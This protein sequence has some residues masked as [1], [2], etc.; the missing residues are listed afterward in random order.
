LDPNIV[1]H[2]RLEV[3]NDV[4]SD[5]RDVESRRSAILRMVNG[6]ASSCLVISHCSNVL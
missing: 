3:A 4:F 1:R 6:M 5:M 2:Q